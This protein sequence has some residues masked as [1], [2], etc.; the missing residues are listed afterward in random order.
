MR[1]I[2]ELLAV[3]APHSMLDLFGGAPFSHGASKFC[4]EHASRSERPGSRVF[5]GDCDYTSARDEAYKRRTSGSARRRI[6]E[7]HGRMTEGALSIGWLQVIVLAI[8]QGITEF[9]PISSSGHLILVPKFTSWP[10]Q[11]LA[12]D[13]A[14]HLGTL[15]AVVFYFREELG[16]MSADLSRSIRMRRP[17]GDSRLA[18]AVLWGTIPVGLAGLV[19]DDT[20]EMRLRAPVL[21][22]ATTIGFGLLLWVADYRKG[23]RSEHELSWR[24][25]LVIGCA[26]ALALVPGTSRSGVTISA[27]MLL[28]LSREGAARFSFLLAVPVTALAGGLKIAQ[29]ASRAEPVEWAPFFVGAALAAATAFL[30]IHYFL[31]WVT[32]FGLM[33]FVLYRLALGAV[34]LT[35]LVF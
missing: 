16:R 24:D 8:V 33:P 10:D 9:L 15:A 27:A 4:K 25:V 12:F 3:I 22:A 29:L 30:C 31:K 13:L 35:A 14:V 11:G 28:G 23:E 21:I 17:V 18:W 2:R 7:E 5:R 32:R 6:L 34:I 1:R 19:F 20:I 26:Q